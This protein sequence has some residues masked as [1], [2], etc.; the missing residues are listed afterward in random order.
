MSFSSI[1]ITHTPSPPSLQKILEYKSIQHNSNTQA[2]NIMYSYIQ[3]N[4]DV[5]P[6]VTMFSDDSL[7]FR[8]LVWGSWEYYIENLKY[9]N[10]VFRNIEIVLLTILRR[11]WLFFSLY[12]SVVRALVIW[13]QAPFLVILLNI[14]RAKKH[15]WTYNPAHS[16]FVYWCFKLLMIRSVVY[17][18]IMLYTYYSI[19]GY[20][21]N[22]VYPWSTLS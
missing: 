3:V 22:Y 13:I 5:K 16:I 11:P 1:W 2:K 7:I 14:V 12:S 19:Q 18:T 20:V 8:Y 9:I 15:L 21:P 17:D 10:Y 6:D 4:T